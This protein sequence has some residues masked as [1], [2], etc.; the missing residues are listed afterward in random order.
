MNLQI[1]GRLCYCIV[2]LFHLL[3][4]SYSIYKQNSPN[5]YSFFITLT[6]ENIHGP[7]TST[8]ILEFF[9]SNTFS[10]FLSLDIYLRYIYYRYTFTKAEGKYRNRSHVSLSSKAKGDIYTTMHKGAFTIQISLD[11]ATENKS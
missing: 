1:H 3:F 2:N 6:S 7:E 4:S 10:L 5:L 8:Y 9:N 11:M